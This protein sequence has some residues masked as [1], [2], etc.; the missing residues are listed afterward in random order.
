[1]RIKNYLI[2]VAV[3]LLNI[4]LSS[5]NNVQ[6]EG[7][8]FNQI[9]HYIDNYYVDTVN[10]KHLVEKAISE[11]LHK[12]DPH[13]YYISSEEIERMKE[14]LEGSFDG[15]GIQFNIMED[16]LLV[17]GVI[18]GGPSEKVGL[19]NGDR[20]IMVNDS[21]IAGVGLKNDQVI[22]LLRGKKGT[23][24]KVSVK[25]SSKKEP[26]DFIITRDKIPIYSVDAAY[27]TD[28]NIGYI[29]LSRF[30]KTSMEELDS[31]F[32]IFVKSGIKDIILDL[33]GNSGGYLDQAV[34]LADEFL[35]AD[36]LI[37][38]T[39]GLHIPKY[40]YKS[41]KSGR[42]YK[43]RLVVIVDEG[44]A[45][46]SE[47]VSGAIQD[48]DRGIVIGRRTFG[49]GLVQR[50]MPLNDGSA[51]RITI[52]R[53]YTPT[54][55]SI[56]KPYSDNIDDY[57]KDILNR[58]KHGEFMNKD[59]IVF[60]D[61]LKYT[62]LVN[63]RTVYGGGGIMPDD[64]IPIDTTL[65]SDFHNELLRKGVLF[66]FVTKY[67]DQNRQELKKYKDVN[68]FKKNFDVNEAILNQLSE[69][70]KAKNINIDS[71]P[72]A[73]VEQNDYLKNHIKA[74]LAN[75]IWTNKEFWQVFNDYNPYFIR[76]KEIINDKK[77]YD[78]ILKGTN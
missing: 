3:L 32:N 68:D 60:A 43:G 52:S 20:I 69:E 63:K 17:V 55:R 28:E 45:S 76:A 64:F 19:I 56:Q 7:Q 23:T 61:S 48:W 44:S 21:L 65:R 12:M 67:S 40:D 26:I 4:Q 47:I 58:Y 72:K 42:F 9:L 18:N 22:K 70:A 39:Q 46:A 62:T 16:T 33:S 49:K 14:P 2:I 5:Q 54:G 41:S 8:K 51:V 66:P 74:L 73:T 27:T 34:K 13:S 77:L 24:V 75:D 36:K 71:L 10:I 78:N 37:V 29:R 35:Q 50:E 25:R 38:Y 31:V 30:A 53:Y 6:I 59:S 1:M 11:M 57:N 15:I